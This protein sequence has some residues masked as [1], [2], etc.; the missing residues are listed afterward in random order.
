MTNGDVMREHAKATGVPLVSIWKA[1]E[2]LAKAKR[3]KADV[4][5]ARLMLRYGRLTDEARDYVTR[6]YAR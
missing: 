5:L 1:Q 6:E 2:G 3:T 4:T